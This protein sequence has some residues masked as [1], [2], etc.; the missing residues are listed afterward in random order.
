M[1]LIIKSTKDK[2]SLS[3]NALVYGGDDVDMTALI[4]ELDDVLVLNANDAMSALADQ[5]VDF[6]DCKTYEQA[7]EIALALRT[8][9]LKKYKSV[10]FNTV[11]EFGQHVF[12]VIKD[13][14]DKRAKDNG[15][16][17]ADGRQY[18]G[19]F[20]QTI[21]RVIKSFR[22]ANKDLYVFADAT[23]KENDQAQLITVPDIYGKASYEISAWLGEVFYMF[24][25]D[26]KDHFLTKATD[27]ITARD[28]SGKL[29]QIEPASLSHVKE[30]ILG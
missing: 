27:K 14:A 25:K 29:E 19:E 5:D 26:G 23:Q 15:S 8:D 1:S 3:L 24:N 6:V 16:K 13:R 20:K 18:W 30:K 10:V 2:A 17:G 22:G 12:P 11:T 7:Q 9:E 28:L 21:S 4:S